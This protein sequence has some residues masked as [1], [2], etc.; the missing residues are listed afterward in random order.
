MTN[1]CIITIGDEL[2][3]G[4]VVNTNVGWIAQRL[5]NLGINVVRTVTVGDDNADILNILRESYENTDLII[6]TGGLGPTND[7]I[8][9]K[10]ACEFFDCNLVFNEEMYRNV[11]RVF[12]I[13]GF[14]ITESNRNQAMVP[15]KC[16]P[17]LNE[18][19]TAPGMLFTEANKM[20]VFL[21]GVP[22]E[23]KG[24]M[25]D[26]VIPAIREKYKLSGVYYRTVMTQGLGE[27]FVAERI[28]EWEKALPSNIKFAYLP[29]YGSV[30]LRITAY[31]NDME[32]NKRVVDAK[33]AELVAL[34][35]DIVYG[36]DDETLAEAVGK[37]LN[38][39]SMTVSTAESC[40]GGYI[41]HLITSVPGS[42]EYF[43]GS[44]VAYSN[45]VKMNV[46]NVSE[47][48]LKKYGA[49]SEETV[50]EMAQG[51][52]N[53]MNTDTAVVTSGIAGP[54][55]GTPE[56]PV[57]TVWIAVAVDQK[58]VTK[59]C[60]FGDNREINIEC[61][62]NTALKTLYDTINTINK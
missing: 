50:R 1:C 15:D 11:V 52:L 41:A 13:R 37:A 19:G 24:L 38:R 28:Q 57:G 33:T 51:V 3:I 46:L 2:L 36:Y 59:E 61:A 20:V 48:T 31:G 8:T 42:S 32:A 35:P 40:T 21:P 47:D 53:V 27:S 45:E 16:T 17:L 43:K 34:I 49:V 30:K 62:A 14:A 29:K 39:H 22:R 55:G 26:A 44:V 54:S 5:G 56:K 7:D 12:T 58:I 9:K 4:Q 60:H 6:V 23:M 10:C 18:C 25:N